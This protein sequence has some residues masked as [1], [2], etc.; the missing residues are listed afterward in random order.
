M[1][2]MSNQTKRGVDRCG[3]CRCCE[4]RDARMVGPSIPYEVL[5]VNGFPATTP[6]NDLLGHVMMSVK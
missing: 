4:W 2:L 1:S 6:F 5:V 3:G